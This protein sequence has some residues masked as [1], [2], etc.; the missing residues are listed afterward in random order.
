MRADDETAVR[1]VETEYDAA[2]DA[3]DIP[4]ILACLTEDAVLVTPHGETVIGHA[5]IR[6]EL[7]LV[8]SRFGGDS[9]HTS[10]LSRVTF[11]SPEVAVVDGEARVV[12]GESGPPAASQRHRFTDILLKRRDRWLI[13]HIRTCPVGPDE[14]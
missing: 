3:G 1:G 7:E 6:R 12:S 9:K 10:S 13:A 8:L 14:H 4:G 5:A 11:V 2:W